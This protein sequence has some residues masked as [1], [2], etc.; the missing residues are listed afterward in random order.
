MIK[1]MTR[2]MARLFTV[3]LAV[4]AAVAILTM[5]WLLYRD[6]P[7]TADSVAVG[8]YWAAFLSAIGIGSTG[9]NSGERQFV[10]SSVVGGRSFPAEHG[11][12]VDQR[13]S[14]AWYAAS[15]MVTCALV[16]GLLNWL[17]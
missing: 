5:G 16:G 7:I 8:L 4:A 12:N 11:R 2:L 14:F 3:G 6:T 17:G 9:M 13:I 1:D 10:W 15:A